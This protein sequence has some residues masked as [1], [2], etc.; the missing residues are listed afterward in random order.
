MSA[1]PVAAGFLARDQT[2]YTLD[3]SGKVE[4]DGKLLEKCANA[5][6]GAM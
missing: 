3:D 6:S 1:L 4:V 2:F 5:V